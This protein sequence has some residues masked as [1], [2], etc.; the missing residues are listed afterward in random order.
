MSN[1]PMNPE[2]WD[3]IK[4]KGVLD[5]TEKDKSSYWEKRYRE[6]SDNKYGCLMYSPELE[7]FR[8]VTFMENRLIMK[9]DLALWLL[10]FRIFRVFCIKQYIRYVELARDDCQPL[11]NSNL[12][13]LCNYQRRP[14]LNSALSWLPCWTKIKEVQENESSQYVRK[15]VCTTFTQFNNDLHRLRFLEECLEKAK[16]GK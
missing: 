15:V 14:Y 11:S 6:G 8:H 12:M 3:E 7:R 10:R 16:N 4:S 5:K 1:T 2:M 13:F 9:K